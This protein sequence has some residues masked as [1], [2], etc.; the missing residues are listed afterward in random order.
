MVYIIGLTR[1]EFLVGDVLFPKAEYNEEELARGRKTVL[2]LS[3]EDWEKLKD[4]PEVADILA[5]GFFSVLD[6]A[7]VDKFSLNSDLQA[8]LQQSEASRV[9]LQQKYNALKAEYDKLQTEAVKTI[10]D[11][12][13]EID[14]LKA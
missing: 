11:L 5:Q 3:D 7:P 14:I 10:Q 1:K 2:T 9:D 4:K 8:A 6:E 12:Q 13:D